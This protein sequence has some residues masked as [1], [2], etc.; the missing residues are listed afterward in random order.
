LFL[1]CAL[2]RGVGVALGTPNDLDVMK[3]TYTFPNKVGASA[4]EA[5]NET[6]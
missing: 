4:T 3:F 6:I 2:F 1:A 5:G